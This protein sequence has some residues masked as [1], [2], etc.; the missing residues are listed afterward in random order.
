MN[1]LAKSNTLHFA[2]AELA[3]QLAN[4]LQGANPFSDA[5]NGLFL[6]AP[7]REG[8]SVFLLTPTES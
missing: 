3:A 8:K 6:A 2:R 4:D 7:R 1:T 5:P